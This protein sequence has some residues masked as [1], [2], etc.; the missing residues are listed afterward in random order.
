M[1]SNRHPKPHVGKK[2]R[3]DLQQNPG[4]GSSKGSFASG[5]D[6]EETAGDSTVEG[7]IANDTTRAGGIDP[8]QLGRTNK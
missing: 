7:D 1:S 2:P 3:D 5:E 4:I 6:P 8:K